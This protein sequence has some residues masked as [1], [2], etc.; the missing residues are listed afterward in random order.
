MV[1]RV[2]V[3]DDVFT[4]REELKSMLQGHGYKVAGEASNGEQA[5][6]AFRNLR[7]DLV[8]LDLVLPR[9][10]GIEA[11]RQI[12]SEDPDARIIG[13]C[14]LVHPSVQGEAVRAGLRGFVPKPVDVD[15]LMPEIEDALA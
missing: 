10:N 12:L 1:V 2:L 11:A 14:G 7:P 13:V 6:E 8:L 4:D 5:V 9:M 15:L 3:V